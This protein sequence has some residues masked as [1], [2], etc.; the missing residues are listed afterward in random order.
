MQTLKE[1][2]CVCV[3]VCVCVCINV[4]DEKVPQTYGEKDGLFH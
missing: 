3:C 1:T 2:L 4:T